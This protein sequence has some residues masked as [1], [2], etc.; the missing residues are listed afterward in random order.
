MLTELAAVEAAYHALHELDHAARR[1]ALH[2]LTDAL[3][4]TVVTD[5]LDHTNT[6]QAQSLS[7]V[8]APAPAQPS[9]GR[10]TRSSSNGRRANTTRGRARSVG[11][12]ARSRTRSQRQIP[13]AAGERAYRR[14]PAPDD[15][16][17]AYRKVGTVSGLAEHF[18]VPRHTVQGWARRLRGLGYQIG[19]QD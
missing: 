4:A 14:M 2:W 11:S 6:H 16:L 18:D 8:E 19:R 10:A 7:T 9:P 12:A 3:G 1:R 5:Q 15:V 17:A 13:P